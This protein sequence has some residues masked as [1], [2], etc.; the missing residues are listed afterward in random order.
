MASESEARRVLWDVSNE[1]FVHPRRSYD[2][3]SGAG[4]SAANEPRASS[5]EEITIPVH[6]LASADNTHDWTPGSHV[7]WYAS[8]RERT[9]R[10]QDYDI[11]RIA[12]QPRDEVFTN[13][14]GDHVT[15]FENRT[16]RSNSVPVSGLAPKKSTRQRSVLGNRHNVYGLGVQW[17]KT[18]LPTLKESASSGSLLSAAQQ[19]HAVNSHA[20]P[21][22]SSPEQM[23]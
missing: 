21:A 6:L 5:V 20:E 14:T 10:C 3:E 17:R 13:A 1:G 19:P 8:A 18:S 12:R 11:V 15:D 4:A 22:A 16:V 9:D 2:L 7:R 23:G